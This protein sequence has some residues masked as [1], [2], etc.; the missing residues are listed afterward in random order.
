MSSNQRKP[1]IDMAKG[2]GIILVIFG[3]AMTGENI[4]VSWQCTFFMPMFFICSGLCYTKP[5]ALL[6]NVRKTLIPYYMGGG[7]G[8][9][10][11]MSLLLTKDGL[12]I[13]QIVQRIFSFLIGTSM[14]NYPLWF[15]VAFFVCKCVFDWIMMISFERKSSTYIQSMAA[16][17]CFAVGLCLANLRRKYGFFYPFRA[18]IG[19]T[20]VPFMLIGYYS[21]QI[22]DHMAC[23]PILKQMASV[24]VLLAINVASF[25]HNTLVSVNSSDYGNPVFFLIGAVSGSY[26]VILLCQIICRIPA[27][28]KVLSWYGRNSLT[29]MCSHAIVL[30]FLAKLFL[31]VK[32]FIDI[33]N[34]LL[35]SAKF[36]CC[37]LAM[38]PL[39]LLLSAVKVRYGAH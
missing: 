19:I 15:L 27:L 39:C 37:V 32:R 11:E 23:L 17:L 33:S 3:H 4:I 36:V 26:F 10:I 30:M 22:V 21:K 14:W 7:I 1:F 29:I 6:E 28:E 25:C 8:L 38:I 13:A 20:L 5:K 12:D 16:L 24:C 2:I 34:G 18:D 35:D 9:C 31:M